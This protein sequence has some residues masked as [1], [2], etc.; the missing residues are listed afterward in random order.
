MITTNDLPALIAALRERQPQADWHESTDPDIGPVARCR[1]D[2]LVWLPKP[3]DAYRRVAADGSV[4]WVSVRIL[5]TWGDT[6]L[7]LERPITD[8]AEAICE[9]MRAA[10]ADHAARL[11]RKEDALEALRVAVGDQP[12]LTGVSAEGVARLAASLKPADADEVKVRQVMPLTD[13]DTVVLLRAHKSWGVIARAVEAM[14]PI[15]LTRNVLM[16]GLWVRCDH[17]A[18]LRLKS[19]L[20]HLAA[21]ARE[22]EEP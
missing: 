2:V 15:K 20:S 13:D 19:A 11:A 4:L 16:P 6:A 8:G 7:H 18:T 1:A 5:G 9:A 3:E 12:V 14:A 10:V 21:V 22:W 17:A